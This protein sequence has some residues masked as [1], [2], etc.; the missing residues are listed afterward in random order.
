MV[1]IK[2]RGGGGGGGGGGYN[3]VQGEGVGGECDRCLNL[4]NE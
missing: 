4:V 1:Y 3:E 2:D